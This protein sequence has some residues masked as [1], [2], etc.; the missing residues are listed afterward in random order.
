MAS[1]SDGYVATLRNSWNSLSAPVKRNLIWA[2]VIPFLV[3]VVLIVVELLPGIVANNAPGL[4]N[5]TTLILYIGPLSLVVIAIALISYYLLF[6]AHHSIRARYLGLRYPE[7]SDALKN[8][9]SA[10]DGWLLGIWLIAIT[11]VP[12]NIANLVL[13]LSTGSLLS[14]DNIS[15]IVWLIVGFAL[16]PLCCHRFILMDEGTATAG[17]T[18]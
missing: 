2:T 12:M 3:A 14:T 4:L 17:M 6:Q 10:K 5:L 1:H 15:T 7:D 9:W 8:H 16:A 18:G 11:A 13:S